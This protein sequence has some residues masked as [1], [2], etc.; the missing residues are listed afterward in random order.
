M[1]EQ[2][3]KIT[4]EKHYMSQEDISTILQLEQL[5]QAEEHRQLQKIA[6]LSQKQ[7][8]K[9][10]YPKYQTYIKKVIAWL[11]IFNAKI[12][13]RKFQDHLIPRITIRHANYD[14]L[15]RLA[16][17]VKL[18][19]I[20]NTRRIATPPFTITKAWTLT[21]IYDMAFLLKQVTPYIRTQRTKRI[22]TL[23]KSFCDSRAKHLEEPYTPQEQQLAEQIKTLNTTPSRNTITFLR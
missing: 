1:P 9:Q 19:E 14:A 23:L 6:S 11:L 15:H 4:T 20:G 17:I 2:L 18:G 22:A 7:R 16:Q 12:E 21:N 8:P 5:I 13:I 10:A 3:H